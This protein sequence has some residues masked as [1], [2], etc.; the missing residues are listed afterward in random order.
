MTATMT[1]TTFTEGDYVQLNHVFSGGDIT[2]ATKAELERFTVMLSRPNA[3]THL[4]TASFPQ[5]CETVRMLLQARISEEANIKTSRSPIELSKL[6]PWPAIRGVLLELSSYEVPKVVDRAGLKVDWKLTTQKDYSD[7]M[8]IAAYRPRIDT[9]Y[10]ALSEAD[11]LR[12]SYIVA[13][14]LALRGL[15]E[16]LDATLRA[17]GWR[18]E[19]GKLMPHTAPVRE[20]FFPRHSQHDAYVEVRSIL[21]TASKSITIVDPYLDQTTLT[22]LTSSLRPGMVVRLLTS[23]LPVDFMLEAK[24]WLAQHPHIT[25]EVRTTKEFHDR[26]VVVDDLSCWHVGCSIKDAGNKAFMLSAVEDGA[27]RAALLAQIEASWRA[28]TQRL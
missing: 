4:G 6:H 17:V 14:E 2:K 22:L 27:N 12:A 3:Y 25:L 23:K 16:K 15:G 5:I 13:D 24:A 20:L 8:R 10:D 26:F 28:G 21:Q 18:I 1:P 9:A 19:A 11:Q 7:K